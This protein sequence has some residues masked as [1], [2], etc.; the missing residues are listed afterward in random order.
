MQTQSP[1]YLPPRIRKIIKLSKRSTGFDPY[2]LETPQ[3]SNLKHRTALIPRSLISD[4]ASL[5]LHC[6]IQKPGHGFLGAPEILIR[7]FHW[8]HRRSRR[9]LGL[10]RERF[11]KRDDA[12]G[13]RSANLCAPFLSGSVTRRSVGSPS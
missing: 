7:L 8:D 9:E 3:R 1:N 6:P 5:G 12:D 2:R 11:E 10:A 4:P 13:W